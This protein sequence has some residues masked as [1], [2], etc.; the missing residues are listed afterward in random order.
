MN[1]PRLER[2]PILLGIFMLSLA[3][4]AGR[5]VQLSG[6][7]VPQVAASGDLIHPQRG[8]IWDR[9]GRLLA[10]ETYDR[11]EIIVDK[12]HV[13][14]P[15]ALALALAPAL[16]EPA[17]DIQ[18]RLAA[19]DPRWETLERFALPDAADAI[20]AL[21]NEALTARQ[22]PSRAYPYGADLAHILG[23]VDLDLVGHFGVEEGHADLLRGLEGRRP[24]RFRTD[25]EAFIP[26]L[27][28]ADIVLTIDAELQIAAMDALQGMVEEQNGSGGTVIVL[29]PTTGAILASA[30]TPTY[31]PNNYSAY[32][33]ERFT[34]P[35]VASI[36]P[37]GSVIK[38]LTLAAAFDAG[39][40]GPDSTYMDEPEV[41]MGGI[42]IVNPDRLGHGVTTM[43]EMLTLSLNVGA[44]HVARTL[45]TER[46]Y[47]ALQAF[48]LGRTTGVDLAREVDGIMP[49]P[50]EA[51]WDDER[52][53]FNTFGQGFST[54]PLQ[55][56]VAMGA[57]ANE[58]RRMRPFV[59]GSRISVSGEE[60]LTTPQ[61][62]AQVVTP[63]TARTITAMLERVVEDRLTAA[64]IPGIRVAGKTGTSE[65]PGDDGKNA[66]IATFVGYL[67]AEAPRLVIL[68]KVD[69]PDN[70]SGTHVAAPLFREVAEAAIRVLGI[71]VAA[72]GSE[73]GGSAGGAR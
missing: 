35:A 10:T 11:F 37:P 51:L 36:Y 29:D 4:I 57:L 5:I 19:P 16:G 42:G 49:L 72:A 21:D 9:V 48:G 68:A 31:D 6:S 14:D 41:R 40:L 26:P 8:A 38:P 20:M 2:L 39:L 13:E 71:G 58:G 46:F 69:H 50:G 12:A 44:S 15:A 65:I 47:G 7:P 34:D 64:A 67:P 17:A 1:T 24:G 27:D 3:G 30:S 59:V 33:F 63:A 73:I 53:A 43:Q 45:G 61:L 54:T 18:R 25:P 32:D 23:F 22:N 70:A 60:V 55:V 52:F 66:T 28:G 62:A 56:A